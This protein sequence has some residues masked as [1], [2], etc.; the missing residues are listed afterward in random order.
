MG[1]TYRP[2]PLLYLV[3]SW[4]WV[5]EIDKKMALQNYGVNWTPFVDGQLQFNF[6]YNENLESDINGKV[7][8]M[9]AG[10]RWNITRRSYLNVAYQV[11]DTAS[12]TENTKGNIL[13]TTLRVYY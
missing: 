7:R 13:S 5:T 11:I 10:V 4:S 1:V 12:I 6:A 3:A 8:N 9:L 2:F